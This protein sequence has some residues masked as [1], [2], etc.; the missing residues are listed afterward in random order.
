MSYILEALK[1]AEQSRLAAS[2]P[3]LTRV[4]LSAGEP[5]REPGIRLSGLLLAGAV[6]GATAFGW[7]LASPSAAKPNVEKLAVLVPAVR[8]AAA[9]LAASSF[10]QT[11]QMA[12]ASAKSP[13]ETQ[14]TSQA[15]RPWASTSPAWTTNNEQALPKPP[16]TLSVEP[17]AL[18]KDSERTAKKVD[19]SKQKDPG[20]SAGLSGPVAQ[21]AI[22]SD[23]ARRQIT[24]SAGDLPVLKAARGLRVFR[25]EELPSELRRELPKLS[26]TGYV[27][28]AEP[29]G[30][31]VNINERNLREGDEFMAGMK[32]ELITPEYVLFRFHGYRFRIEMF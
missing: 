29:D 26:A 16:I 22:A 20:D 4:A 7:W 18:S 31:I 9:P 5:V 13:H 28:S 15:T 19:S 21:E 1:K 14:G 12:E 30:R 27:D 32:L 24:A 11:V 3:D 23:T 10:R 6:T 2:P 25:L 8:Q 17:A